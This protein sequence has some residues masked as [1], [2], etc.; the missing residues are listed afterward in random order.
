MDLRP[1]KTLGDLNHLQDALLAKPVAV[2]DI[3]GWGNKDKEKEN[4]VGFKAETFTPKPGE[5]VPGGIRSPLHLAKGVLGKQPGPMLQ[6][7]Q[8]KKLGVDRSEFW[9]EL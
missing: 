4:W 8:R 1:L 5:T 3:A 2:H 9:S 6:M 7:R